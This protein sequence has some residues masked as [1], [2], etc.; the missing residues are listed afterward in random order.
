MQEPYL[1]PPVQSVELGL[2]YCGFCLFEW[3]PAPSPSLSGFSGC[4]CPIRII[5]D[6]HGTTVQTSKPNSKKLRGHLNKISVVWHPSVLGYDNSTPTTVLDNGFVWPQPLFYS[7]AALLS[8]MTIANI[9]AT[10]TCSTTMVLFLCLCCNH[11]NVVFIS[12]NIL[13]LSAH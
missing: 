12:M 4:P 1:I 10:P 2:Q 6:V 11:E 3:K 13:C 5:V 7:H 8:V 9:L